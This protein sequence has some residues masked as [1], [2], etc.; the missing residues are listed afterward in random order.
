MLLSDKSLANFGLKQSGKIHKVGLIDQFLGWTGHVTYKHPKFILSI[1]GIISLIS[2]YGISK[3]VIN[4]NPTRWFAKTHPIRIADK[5]MNKHLAGTYMGYLSLQPKPEEKVSDE[6]LDSLV[7]RAESIFTPEQ[8]QSEAAQNLLKTLKTQI[9]TVGKN[10]NNRDDLLMK[11]GDYLEEQ[12][13]NASSNEE[14]LWDKVISAFDAY[15]TE[16]QI[17]KKPEVLHYMEGLQNHLNQ[18]KTV[19]KTSSLVEIVKTVHR[20]LF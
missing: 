17:F 16:L 15:R 18:L 6:Y 7:K 12:I 9:I 13:D 2:F 11:M 1:V 5:V 20:E 19:G 8:L 4:D 10:S 14:E 3:I